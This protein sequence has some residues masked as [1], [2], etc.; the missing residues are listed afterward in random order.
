MENDTNRV[1]ETVSRAHR[2]WL[3]VLVADEVMTLGKPRDI[4][5]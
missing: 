3:D 5:T 2:Q 1:N 4:S